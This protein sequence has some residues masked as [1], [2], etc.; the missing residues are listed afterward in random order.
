MNNPK[1]VEG[2][3]AAAPIRV[4]V[5][6]KVDKKT[7]RIVKFRSNE[8]QAELNDPVFNDKINNGNFF[9]GKKNYKNIEPRFAR[10]ELKFEYDEKS[11]LVT[12]ILPNGFNQIVWE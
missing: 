5:C 4:K 9:T 11:K 12:V 10:E 3:E 8:R 7:I 1:L 2:E 6:F